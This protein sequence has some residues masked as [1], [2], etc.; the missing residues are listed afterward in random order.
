MRCHRSPSFTHST[1]AREYLQ[2]LIETQFNPPNDIFLCPK[3]KH[4]HTC[5]VHT[6]NELRALEGRP[7]L[8]DLP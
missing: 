3:C 8:P 7:T 4:F 5:T 2:L 6:T 1:Y